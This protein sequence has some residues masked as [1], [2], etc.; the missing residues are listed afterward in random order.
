M[1]RRF[2]RALPLRSVR[3]DDRLDVL[4]DFERRHIRRVYRWSLAVSM[5]FSVVGYLLYYLP[6]YACPDWFPSTEITLPVWGKVSVG[7]AGIAYGILLAYLELMLLVLLHLHGIHEI[8]L[9]TGFIDSPESKAEKEELLLNTGMEKRPRRAAS[10]GIDPYQGIHPAALFA[11]DLLLRLKGFLGNQLIRLVVVRLLGRYGARWVLDFSGLPLYMA[12]NAYA[13]HRA[14][15]EAR[16]VLFGNLLLQRFFDQLPQDRFQTPDGQRLLYDTLQLIAVSKR[17]YH[18]NHDVLTG[19][20]L[21]CYRVPLRKKHR[22]SE[23]FADR[24]RA[25]PDEDRRLL[26]EILTLGF[27]LDGRLSRREKKMIGDL[28]AQ[29][30]FPYDAATVEKMEKWAFGEITENEALGAPQKPGPPETFR[31]PME[32]S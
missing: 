9:A 27:V 16:V 18:H 1:F 31:W 2:F 20:L 13:T 14:Y 32:K 10:Y 23:D 6:Y 11:Y 12:I 3:K 7:L 15:T 29:G 19:R 22:L 25:A 8:A 4:S 5:S 28:Q 24:L 30:L 26:Q 17:D 21:E